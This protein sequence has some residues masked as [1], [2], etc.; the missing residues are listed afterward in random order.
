MIHLYASVSRRYFEP[1]L[2]KSS[3]SPTI[4]ADIS[5]ASFILRMRPATSP[6]LV[7]DIYTC[8]DGAKPKMAPSDNIV[9]K[10]AP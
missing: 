5:D 8:T 1:I 10:T 3:A 9:R 7:L 2:S 6:I 4:F